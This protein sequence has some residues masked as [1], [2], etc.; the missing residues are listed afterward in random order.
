[1][2]KLFVLEKTKISLKMEWIDSVWQIKRKYMHYLVI[3][4]LVLRKLSNYQKIKIY[5]IKKFISSELKTSI[6]KINGGKYLLT[7]V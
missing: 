5:N 4:S 2:S 1:M 7:F 6:H 3:F